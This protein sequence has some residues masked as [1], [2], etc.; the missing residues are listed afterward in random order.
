MRFE[1]KKKKAPVIITIANFQKNFKF[2]FLLMLLLPSS[3]LV[4]TTYL[5]P[6][7]SCSCDCKSLCRRI[8]TW[9]NLKDNVYLK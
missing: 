9:K 2:E 8:F 3:L 6:A 7:Q 1:Q 4:P 5:F